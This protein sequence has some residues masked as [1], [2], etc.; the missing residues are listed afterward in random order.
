[1]EA[2]A[3][4]VRSRWGSL[5]RIP[6]HAFLSFQTATYKKPRKWLAFFKHFLVLQPSIHSLLLHDVSS[7]SGPDLLFLGLCRCWIYSCWVWSTIC[8][9]QTLLSCPACLSFLLV[10][11]DRM[12]CYP[13]C[14]T[15]LPPTC[16]CSWNFSHPDG[17][18]R[19]QILPLVWHLQLLCCSQRVQLS[20]LS[21]SALRQLLGT[22]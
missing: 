19:L 11:K 5:S 15:V 21:S 1:M 4:F 16:S 9:P 17:G 8:I 10:P 18:L 2:M 12:K 14:H 7:L 13:V 22:M 6:H 3:V 20:S